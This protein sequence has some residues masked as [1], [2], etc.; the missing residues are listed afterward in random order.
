MGNGER[1][2]EDTE[3]DSEVHAVHRREWC[4]FV[5]GRFAVFEKR[6]DESSRAVIVGDGVGCDSF[7]LGIESGVPVRYVRMADWLLS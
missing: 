6:T 4:P 3:E 5:G 7:F 1:Q 2:G